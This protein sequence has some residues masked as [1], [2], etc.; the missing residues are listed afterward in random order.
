MR[1]FGL[2]GNPL[3]HSYSGEYFT[4]KFS[5]ERIAGCRYELFPVNEA[6]QIRKIAEDRAELEGLNVTLPFKKPVIPYLDDLDEAAKKI[7]A[8]NCIRIS[9]RKEGI[10]LKGYN[11]DAPA[12]RDSLLPLLDARYNRAL[13]LGTGGSAQAVQYALGQ[14]NIGFRLVSRN[15]GSDRLAYG[16]LD[17]AILGDYLLIINTT[18][19]GMYPDTDSCPSIPY[20]SL[21]DRHLLYDVVYNPEMTLFLR[22]GLQ[23]GASV[24]N[25]LDMLRR[26][27]EL[28]W[29]IWNEH[30]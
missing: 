4:R 16:Q 22:N 18:P 12:F 20:S 11:T 25:G 21:T 30:A 27:A 5:D 9:R 13:I 10:Q 29:E 3:G 19:L 15:P 14:L 6:A 23:Q 28:S 1:L 24:K 26:Q 2:T 8:V 7:G 17:K